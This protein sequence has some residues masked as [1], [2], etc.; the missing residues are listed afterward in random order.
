MKELLS[1]KKKL[2][3]IIAVNEK[4]S[5]IVQS[6]LSKK[7][8]D[9]G[10][11]VIPCVIGDGVEE[12]GLANSGAS[13]NVIPYKLYMKL[14]NEDPKPTRMTLQLTGRSVKCQRGVA[15]DMLVVVGKFIFPVDFVLLN[16][17]DD[18][19]VP[20]ILVQP[21]LATA[22]ALYDHHEEKMSL[23]VGDSEVEV[24]AIDPLKQY[25]GELDDS[26]GETERE[27]GDFEGKRKHGDAGKRKKKT[28]S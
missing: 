5:A 6:K 23:R 24:P 16:V 9:T 11:M 17:N 1:N 26:L 21:F 27:F 14:G 13:I 28:T 3:E 20:I 12:S 2:E 19:E 10:S 25:F 22:G 18:V 8:K 15:E 4:C 7:L